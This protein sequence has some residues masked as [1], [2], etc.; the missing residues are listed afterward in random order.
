MSFYQP[1]KNGRPRNRVA[2]SGAR[3]TR[4]ISAEEEMEEV[5][6]LLERLCKL[7][8]C[9]YSWSDNL[10]DDSNP[11]LE[12]LSLFEAIEIVLK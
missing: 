6:V 9:A 7:R 3:P 4:T 5:I 10:L 1:V 2:L 12:Q 11:L 8:D